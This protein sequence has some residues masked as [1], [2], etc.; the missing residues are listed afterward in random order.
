MPQ[1]KKG[2]LR[3]GI[4]KTATAELLKDYSYHELTLDRI[5]SRADIPLSVFYHYFN[6]KKELVL[7]LIE[8]VFVELA[9]TV[10]AQAP[11]GTWERGIRHEQL[12][13]LTLFSENVG[14]M[15]CL[16]EVE[17]LEFSQRWRQK[18]T[19]WHSRMA[20]S[21]REFAGAE[22]P[23]EDELFAIIRALGGMTS[24]FAYQLVVARDER[25]NRTFPDLDSAADFLNA[26]WIRT[27]FLQH[28]TR[29]ADRFETL[30]SLHDFD[31]QAQKG[32]NSPASREPAPPARRAKSPGRPKTLGKKTD[33]AQK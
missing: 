2:R 14:L 16:H 22:T 29:L 15:R 6:T 23:D 1:T 11:H 5:T 12:S 3:R 27:L 21:L 13:L 10:N 20:H 18:I 9:S 7:E 8:E 19:E 25:L 4:L 33:K 17:D 31:T 30:Q 28:P 24:E 26:L 32:G